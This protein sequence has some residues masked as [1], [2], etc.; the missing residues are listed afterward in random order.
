L[1]GKLK[2][3]KYS[4]F[5]KNMLS[6]LGGIFFKKE[7]NYSFLKMFNNFLAKKLKNIFFLFKNTYYFVGGKT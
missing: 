1:E 6:L 3:R 2:K 4:F 5:K 7:T